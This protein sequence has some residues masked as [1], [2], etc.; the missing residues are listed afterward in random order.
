[1]RVLIVDDNEE[2]GGFL[3]ACLREAGIESVVTRDAEGALRLVENEKFDVLAVDS[4]LHES[5]GTELVQQIRA[6][7]KGRAIPVLLMS[8][9]G[10]ALARRMATLAGCNEFL[11]K[12]FGPSQ[13]VEQL[14]SLRKSAR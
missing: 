3:A 2:L 10:T 11:V 4:V 8:G 7:K 1:M 12:P 9:I 13:L 5:A 6:T 14:Q